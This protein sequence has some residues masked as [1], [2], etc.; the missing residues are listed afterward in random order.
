MK[1]QYQ[2]VN[3]DC[4][5]CAAKMENAIKKLSGVNSASVN[6]ITQR[7]ILDAEDS[8]FDKIIN[9]VIKL[10]KKIEPDCTIKI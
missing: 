6:F 5:N 4:A 1:K 3:L 9:E 10:C 8:H 7:L 2:L